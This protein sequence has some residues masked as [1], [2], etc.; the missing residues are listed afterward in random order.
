MEICD[1]LTKPK[2]TQDCMLPRIAACPICASCRLYYSFSCHG[3]R[4]ERCED[5]GFVLT[6]PQPND[7]QLAR[8][9]S[10]SYF[11]GDGTPETAS[12]ISEMKGATA[13]RYLEDIAT[14]RGDKTSGKLLEI[15]CGQ[16][17]F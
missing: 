16:G 8:I 15:G 9:Y 7:E 14:F 2:T 3:Y 17:D 4:L 13:R 6:N 11:L 1:D 12:R 10:E 5:C